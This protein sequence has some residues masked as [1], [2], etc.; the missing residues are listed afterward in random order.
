MRFQEQPH[1]APRIGNG[2]SGVPGQ[3]TLSEADISRLA[4]P[5][6]CI[7]LEG[8]ATGFVVGITKTPRCAESQVKFPSRVPL[9]FLFCEA[10]AVHGSFVSA[11][12][13][14]VW[15]RCYFFWMLLSCGVFPPSIQE[16]DVFSWRV[17]RAPGILKQGGCREC[18]LMTIFL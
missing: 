18:K 9:L 3:R 17:V 8:S 6:V 13:S 4:S 14:L 12:S 16:E 7:P 5:F 15:H 10:V 11:S 1:P 2:I